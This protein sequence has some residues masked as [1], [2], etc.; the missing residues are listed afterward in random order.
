MTFRN[1]PALEL[2]RPEARA[3]ATDALATLEARL[4]LVVRPSIG[5]RDVDGES[6]TS[7]DP[8]AP[9]RVVAR[10]A[11]A[12][13]AHVDDA[14]AVAASGYGGWAARSGHERGAVLQRAASILRGRRPEAAALAL[15]ECGKPWREADADVC[16]AIDFLE[17]YA[18]GAAEL[19]AGRPLLQLP[20]ERN[21]LRYVGRGVAAVIA[22]WNF[23]FA[24]AGGM[25]AAA[26]AV[27]NAVILKPAAQ[28]PACARVLVDALHAGGVP[29]DALQFLPGGDDVGRA[30]VAHPD[31]PTVAFTGSCAAGLEILERAAR[32]APGQRQL[33]R[34]VAEM[35][36]KNGIVVD[37]DAD[38]DEV[39]PG[40]VASAFAFAGQKC[41]AASRVLVHE[42]V[43]DRLVER[44]RGA[45][46]TLRVGRPEDF[47][48]DVPPV[49]DP[50]AQD[51]IA[52]YVAAGGRPA[53]TVEVPTDGYYAAPTLFVDLPD[54]SPV[55]T[56]EIFGPVL[57]LQRVASVAEAC[58]RIDASRF[59]LTGGIYSRSPR[60]IAEVVRRTP[61]GNLYV[62]REIT[63]AMV[64][65]Q[66]FGGGRMSGTGPKAG[67]PDYLLQFVEA[68]AVSE[69]TVRHGLVL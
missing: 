21:T 6:A 29:T 5:G 44:L 13:A 50:E 3:R 4:P 15:R 47:G 57:A 31:V 61:V 22:P 48:T 52:R 35:G 9:E 26:L 14:V 39:V 37:A 62:N 54:D 11:A 46:E 56:D 33:K 27:G 65:R 67:G 23:P 16:E 17:Y 42:A 45:I 59:A 64:G 30:L 7:V 34:V 8:S 1:E 12:T 10:V 19:D 51:R 55:V 60:T 63:G 36:G 18:L 24:I 28:A 69:S 66:P 58:D 49:I 32:V 41:S 68:R 2:R 20:G 40:V 53:A 25:T 43:A 38:L